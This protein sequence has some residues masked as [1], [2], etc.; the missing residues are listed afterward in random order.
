MFSFQ[1]YINYDIFNTKVDIK[2]N[3]NYH[4]NTLENQEKE[5]NNNINLLNNNMYIDINTISNNNSLYILQKENEIIDILNKYCLKNSSYDFNLLTKS[6][7]VLL[8][9]S[10]NLKKRLKQKDITL[11]HNNNLIFRCSYKFCKYKENC[12][13]N[14]SKKK[15]FQ[16]H[17]VHNMVSFDTNILINYITTAKNI[18]YK[19]VSK[20]I[21]TL[22]YVINHMYTELSAKCLYCKENEIENNHI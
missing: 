22:S 20:S 5:F 11:K 2:L 13:F 14:Y 19:D 4:L 21:I 17:Y 6:L 18:N 15:C 1:K 8:K 3:D 7:N 10:N 9:L 16:D 12:L